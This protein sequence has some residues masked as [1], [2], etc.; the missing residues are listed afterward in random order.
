MPKKDR[1]RGGIVLQKIEPRGS[2]DT[3]RSTEPP[4][5]PRSEYR[6]EIPPAVADMD[7][8]AK[9]STDEATLVCW[10]YSSGRSKFPNPVL[11]PSPQPQPFSDPYHRG[12][13]GNRKRRLSAVDANRDFLIS[14]K[15]SAHVAWSDD[16]L[17]SE[18]QS[19]FSDDES[20]GFCRSTDS[21]YSGTKSEGHFPWPSRNPTRMR[22]AVVQSSSPAPSFTSSFTPSFSRR[23]L[24]H[25]IR[26]G[27][28]ASRSTFDCGVVPEITPKRHIAPQRGGNPLAWHTT[29][30]FHALVDESDFPTSVPPIMSLSS[31][32]FSLSGET[33]Q[34]MNLARVVHDG[35]FVF[36]EGKPK[37]RDRIMRG[38]RRSFKSFFGSKV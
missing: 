9:P 16:G 1:L 10:V 38:L 13:M 19:C 17:G 24:Y 15:R 37:K 32:G 28:S 33:E 29:E 35:R 36:H 18:S 31:G 14:S 30:G 21:H 12:Q 8:W 4:D 6:D 22:K 5:T 27:A 23:P 34:R 25:L 11:P 26:G 7:R 3:D 2:L 20:Q